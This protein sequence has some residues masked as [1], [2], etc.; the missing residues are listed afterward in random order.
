MP[1]G[2]EYWDDDDNP[3]PTLR[4]D[5]GGLVYWTK[6]LLGAVAFGLGVSFGVDYVWS[7]VRYVV[8]HW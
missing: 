2:D 3:P 5:I 6:K 7:F 1:W 4:D 8:P